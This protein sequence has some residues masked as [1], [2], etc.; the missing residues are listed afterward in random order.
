MRALAVSRTCQSM[1]T[2]RLT[3]S[4]GHDSSQ[5]FVEVDCQTVNSR[6]V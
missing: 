4:N 1:V 2:F 3:R 6:I 5:G